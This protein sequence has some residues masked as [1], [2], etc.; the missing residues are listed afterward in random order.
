MWA[1]PTGAGLLTDAAKL[2]QQYRPLMERLSKA[3][4]LL[5]SLVTNP[6]QPGMAVETRNLSAS[7]H[8]LGADIHDW[9]FPRWHSFG[10]SSGS[11]T[12]R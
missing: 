4:A 3:R 10:S 12:Y 11:L 7:L 2:W 9:S 8:H 5:D 6:T 1:D